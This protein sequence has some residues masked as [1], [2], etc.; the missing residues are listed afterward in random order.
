[1]LLEV[2]V[3][4]NLYWGSEKGRKREGRPCS[5]AV[6]KITGLSNDFLKHTVVYNVYVYV[7]CMLEVYCIALDH[8]KNQVNKIRTKFFI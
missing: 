8:F 7:V 6:W 1:M 3:S 5:S 2:C 4:E